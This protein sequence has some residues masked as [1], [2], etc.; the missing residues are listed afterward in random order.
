MMTAATQFEITK[1]GMEAVFGY[2]K[3]AINA[4][5][6]ATARSM[7]V[8]TEV[9]EAMAPPQPARQETWEWSGAPR[10][11]GSGLFA[12]EPARPPVVADPLAAWYALIQASGRLWLNRETPS[13]FAWWAWTPQ[14]AIPATWPWA[15]G[16]ISS[17]VPGSVAWPMA[18]ANVALLDAAKKTAEATRAPFPAYHSGSGFAGHAWTQPDL[19]KTM[20]TA[21]PAAAMMWPWLDGAV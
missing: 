4:S 1:L 17:G 21:A 10:R 11:P 19:I 13:P 3:A 18:E 6:E 9:A 20:L 16:M 14:S 7:A 15:Y 2:A 5:F 12:A 8:W